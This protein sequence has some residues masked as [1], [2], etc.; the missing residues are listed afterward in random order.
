[1]AKQG[2]NAAGDRW[3]DTGQKPP[4]PTDAQAAQ[5]LSVA[6]ERTITRML[7]DLLREHHEPYSYAWFW[8]VALQRVHGISVEKRKK[9]TAALVEVEAPGKARQPRRRRAPRPRVHTTAP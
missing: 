9:A 3:A 1:M 5:L 8:G 7:E 2:R 4:Q 6:D